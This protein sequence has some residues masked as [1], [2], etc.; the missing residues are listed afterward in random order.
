MSSKAGILPFSDL[1]GYLRLYY[2]YS[3]TLGLKT[4]KGI[5][6]DSTRLNH[7][8]DGGKVLGPPIHRLLVVQVRPGR[9]VDLCISN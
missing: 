4:I 7:G 1:L 5:V 3:D 8:V 9:R 6:S 2:M